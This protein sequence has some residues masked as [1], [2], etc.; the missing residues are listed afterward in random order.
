MTGARRVVLAAVV[1]VDVVELAAQAGGEGHAVPGIAIALVAAAFLAAFARGRSPLATGLA[2]LA[3]LAVLES[4]AAAFSFGHQRV[5]FASGATLAGWLVG[6]AFARAATQ[7][8]SGDHGAVVERGDAFAEAGAI[9]GLAATYVDSGLSKLLN[10]GLAWADASSVQTAILTQHAVDDSSPLGRYSAFVVEH[11][12][13][14]FAL[15]SATLVLELGAF[16]MIVGPRIRAAWAVLL[17]GFHVNVSLVTQTIFYVQ[18]CV[19][20]LAF[21]FPLDRAPPPV[22][23]PGRSRLA[24]RATARWVV[25]AVAAAWLVRELSSLGP[26]ASRAGP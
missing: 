2:A 22:V 16:L 15:A 24:V 23:A 4:V 6:L 20:L 13:A 5:H 10:G 12:G 21:A 14:A 3:A 19:L 8:E 9:A 18:A 25:V 26:L 11:R 17:V 7:A 1:A